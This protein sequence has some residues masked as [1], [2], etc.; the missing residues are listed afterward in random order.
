MNIDNYPYYLQD[1]GPKGSRSKH[2]GNS[3]ARKGANNA[4]NAVNNATKKIKKDTEKAL[5][6]TKKTVKDAHNRASEHLSKKTANMKKHL[7][8]LHGKTAAGLL[9]LKEGMQDFDWKLFFIISLPLALLLSI[10]YL[11]TSSSPNLL[12]VVGIFTTFFMLAWL[13]VYFFDK[14]SFSNPDTD[15]V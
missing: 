11:V 15:V 3:R 9:S 13:Y 4:R 2:S 8:N 10:I 14:G 7:T 12:Y 1:G 5:E 6:N